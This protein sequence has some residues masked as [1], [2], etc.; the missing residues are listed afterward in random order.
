MASFPYAE[1][2]AVH[3]SLPEQ[4]SKRDEILASLEFMA[5]AEDPSWE[6]G[7]CSGTM[8]CGDHDHYEFL[9]EAFAK[10]SHVNAL[11]RDMC[12]SATKFESEIISMT[13]D[14]LGGSAL[15]ATQPAGIITSG[16]SGS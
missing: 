7:Q 15:S 10:F 9:N 16:G 5:K 11:Q 6:S 8:Y 4:P 14:L 2:F 3:R 13:I 12:P 1:E